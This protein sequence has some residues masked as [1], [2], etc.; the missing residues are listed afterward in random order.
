MVSSCKDTDVPI[1][2]KEFPTEQRLDVGTTPNDMPPVG[3]LGMGTSLGVSVT[4]TLSPVISLREFTVSSSHELVNST[5]AA[6]LNDI[7]TGGGRML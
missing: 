6:H 2:P 1:V 3:V 4:L 5:P 7:L